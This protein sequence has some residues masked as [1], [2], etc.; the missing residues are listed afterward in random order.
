M[1]KLVLGG[2]CAVSGILLIVLMEAAVHLPALAWLDS[3]TPTDLVRQL[4]IL[5]GGA[6]VYAAGSL[7]AYRTAAARFE[8]VDL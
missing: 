8:R 6:V 1:K 2:A 3:L 5:C 7:L 4:P